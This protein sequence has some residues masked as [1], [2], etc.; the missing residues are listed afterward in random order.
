M[1][2]T[3]RYIFGREQ[4]QKTSTNESNEVKTSSTTQVQSY[5]NKIKAS[6]RCR[7]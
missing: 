2:T 1:A 7:L 3:G 5:V 4:Q 6:Q